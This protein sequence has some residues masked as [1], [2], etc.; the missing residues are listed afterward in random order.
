MVPIFVSNLHKYHRQAPTSSQK[1]RSHPR[2]LP[3]IPIPTPLPSPADF[4]SKY[5]KCTQVSPSPPC[6]LEPP[7]K[8]FS[9]WMPKGSLKLQIW[10]HPFFWTLQWLPTT[11]RTKI[12]T[13]NRGS[14]LF[15]IYSPTSNRSLPHRFYFLRWAMF[16]LA[17]GPLHL[18]FLQPFC[19]LRLIFQI[20]PR[21]CKL[22][23]FM[24][25]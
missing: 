5:F 7:S 21:L 12:K 4:T 6:E 19:L 17:I 14:C 13:P 1:P 15:L 2:L 9:T 25:S 23:P 10:C 8:P 18:L 22:V 3:S 11:H 24:F 20:P 16:S